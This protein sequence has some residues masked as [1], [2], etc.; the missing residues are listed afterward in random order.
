MLVNAR[1]GPAAP[2]ERGSPSLEFVIR[3]LGIRHKGVAKPQR[4]E[5]ALLGVITASNGT[6]QVRVDV[7]VPMTFRDQSDMPEG[8]DELLSTYGPWARHMIWD[9]GAHQ[10]RQLA[11]AT[12]ARIDLPTTTPEASLRLSDGD[13][14]R[15]A[16]TTGSF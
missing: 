12:L 7:V 13:L 5:R 2:E 15:V 10:A 11:S 1:V 16:A 8:D 14:V 9:F 4:P 6:K 3:T